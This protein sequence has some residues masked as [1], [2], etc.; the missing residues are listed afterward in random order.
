MTQ[1]CL[2]TYYRIK[3]QQLL[4]RLNKSFHCSHSGECDTIYLDVPV[5]FNLNFNVNGYPV[6]SVTFEFATAFV[7]A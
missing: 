5:V 6:S 3:F 1:I 4:S 7:V 2:C